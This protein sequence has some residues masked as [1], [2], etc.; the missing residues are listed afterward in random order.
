MQPF[1]FIALDNPF[2]PNYGGT[3]DIHYRLKWFISYNLIHKVYFFQKSEIKQHE[4]K[5]YHFPIYPIKRNMNLLNW[6]SII[7]FTILSRKSDFLWNE[8]IKDHYPIWLEGI[9]TSYFLPKIKKIQ[10]YRKV[11]IR[12]HNYESQ[13]YR[14]LSQ[15]SFSYYQKIFYFTESLKLHQWETRI[16]SLADKL[17]CIS[18][19]ETEL[20]KFINPKCFFL[21]SFVPN[22]HI[23]D[24]QLPNKPYRLVFHGNF[25][26]VSNQKSAYWLINFKKVYPEYRIAL[27]GNNARLFSNCLVEILDNNLPLEEQLIENDI[28]VLPVFQETGVKIKFL[29]SFRMGKPVITTKQAFEGTG[30]FPCL[31]F[32]NY[33][34]LHQIIQFLP[35]HIDCF[36]CTYKNFKKVYNNEENFKWLLKQLET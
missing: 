30:I 32:Q 19:K 31:F 11:F 5:P 12:V 13:Y 28:F 22:N 10:P 8:L 14:E 20:I 18:E 27:Y 21:T 29:E 17:F 4:I 2:I 33:E 15:F 16:W 9:H 35:N 6:L 23:W 7:P 1:H 26:V 3:W 36:V 25:D 34:D 24:F